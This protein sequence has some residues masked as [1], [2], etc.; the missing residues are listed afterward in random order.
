[1]INNSRAVL[2]RC[3]GYK[4]EFY[5]EHYMCIFILLSNFIKK[6]MMELVDMNSLGLFDF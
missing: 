5:I 1:M 2:L 3:L 4:F 6:V